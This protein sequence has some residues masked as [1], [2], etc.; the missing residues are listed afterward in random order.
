[1]AKLLLLND[2]ST[3]LAG[4]KS[5]F[6]NVWTGIAP[7]GERITA[8]Q[9]Y[10]AYRD[11]EVSADE[12]FKD[13]PILLTGPIDKISKD[14]FGSVYLVLNAGGLFESAH[15]TLAEESAARAGSFSRGTTISLLCT[16]SGMILMSPMLKDCQSSDIFFALHRPAIER[17]ADDLLAGGG[18]Q[19]S[20][21]AKIAI[22]LGYAWGT[23][24]PHGNACETVT[25]DNM[26]ECAAA[27]HK[28]P[29]STLTAAYAALAKKTPLPPWPAIPLTQRATNGPR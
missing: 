27:M 26:V 6:A 23:T 25:P 19:L 1:M 4:G 7:L 10:V 22:G 24:M 18:A 3:Y 15:A 9:L 12:R 17:M 28:V 5:E 8:R 20:D 29:K 2:F 16:G 14:I 21:D 13:K 11:N